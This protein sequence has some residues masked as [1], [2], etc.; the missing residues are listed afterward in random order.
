MNGILMDGRTYRVRVVHDSLKRA[1][2][3]RSGENE[4]YMLSGRHERDLLGT[5]YAYSL[6]VEPDPLYPAEYDEFY[7]AISAPVAS[8][9]ITLP[10]GQ[11]TMSFEAE[12]L[13]GE[14]GFWGKI[15]GVNRWHGLVVEYHPIALQ[16]KPN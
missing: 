13:S 12:I 11:T 5:G 7:E 14:D 3:L 8:H 15:G 9:Q 1:F 4:S 2:E 10:Y 16:L 6:A